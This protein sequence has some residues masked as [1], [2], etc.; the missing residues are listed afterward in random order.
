MFNPV[1]VKKFKGDSFVALKVFPKNVES[2]I[3][4]FWN[5]VNPICAKT[6]MGGVIVEED[7]S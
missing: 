1:C 4:Y 5:L 2:S 6:G 3:C 7:S